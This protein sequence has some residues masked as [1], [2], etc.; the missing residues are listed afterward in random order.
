MMIATMRANGDG[1]A[2]SGEVQRTERGYGVIIDGQRLDEHSSR[3]AA[4]V[5]LGQGIRKRLPKNP[6]DWGVHIHCNTR[7]FD[8]AYGNLRGGGGPSGGASPDP[9]VEEVRRDF[10]GNTLAAAIAHAVNALQQCCR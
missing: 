2:S 8:I 3:E 5:H 9:C 10:R 1:R 6:A 7:P 4:F